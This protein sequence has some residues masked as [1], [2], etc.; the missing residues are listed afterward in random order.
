MTFLVAFV[1]DV[2]LSDAKP[3]T[4]IDF[5]ALAFVRC[6]MGANQ[7]YEIILKSIDRNISC[8]EASVTDVDRPLHTFVFYP[9]VL[10]HFISYVYP[11]T[12]EH[13]G[14]SAKW[15]TSFHIDLCVCADVVSIPFPD[16]DQIAQRMK[17]HANLNL[18]RP[19]LRRDDIHSFDCVSQELKLVNPH[20]GLKSLGKFEIKFPSRMIEFI[21]RLKFNGNSLIWCS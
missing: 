15:R 18:S 16:K 14:M 5:D 9:K 10:G 20:I 8:V 3:S 21:F 7:L 6:S 17:N 4:R 19:Y 1:T 12:A 11:T 13:D 2:S